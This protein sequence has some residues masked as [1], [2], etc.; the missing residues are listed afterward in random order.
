LIQ[1]LVVF[2]P[3]WSPMSMVFYTG[4][5]FPP[6]Y[7]GG[8]FIAFHGSSQRAPLAEEGYEVVFQQF[9]DGLAADY[10]TFA[11]GFAGPSTTVQGAL[12]R[13][14]GLAQGPDGALYLSDDRGGRIWKI[15]YKQPEE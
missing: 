9:K 2:P 11:T 1:P 7:R 3:H 4:K 10:A 15:T 6:Q 13:P 14:V 5:M 8:L 12:H